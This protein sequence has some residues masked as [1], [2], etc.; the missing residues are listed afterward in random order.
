[1]VREVRMTTKAN[2][3]LDTSFS[4]KNVC[5]PADPALPLTP[6]ELIRFYEFSA[7]ASEPRKAGL[8]GR[9]P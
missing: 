2:Q 5:F 1:M 7:K 6:R 3:S 4:G 8:G 9:F